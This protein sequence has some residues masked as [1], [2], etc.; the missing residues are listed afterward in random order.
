MSLGCVGWGEQSGVSSLADL[1]VRSALAV[2]LGINS[3][4]NSAFL[5]LYLAH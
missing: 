3:E 4:L 5:V 2:R 1:K